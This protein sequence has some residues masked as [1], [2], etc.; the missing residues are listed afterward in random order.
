M[1][2]LPV[3]WY[4]N[5]LMAGM[6]A[7]TNQFGQLTAFL[8]A[9]LVNGFN[10]KTVTSLTQTGGIATAN[11]GASHGFLVD[12][13]ILIT[14]VNETD[15]QGEFR[16][17][18]STTSNITFAVSPS[19]PSTATGTITCKAAPLNW[20]IVFTGT[21]K[22]VYRSL[23]PN[24]PKNM[25]RVDDSQDQTGPYPASYAKKA[26]V[27]MVEANGMGGIDTFTGA[28]APWDPTNPNRNH[29]MSGTAP[30]IYDGW[31]KWYYS[32][33]ESWTAGYFDSNP[34]ENTN[35]KPI[36][37]V[38]DTRG[39]YIYIDSVPG[40]GKSGKCFTD[41]NSY[42]A[43]DKYATLLCAQE[44]WLLANQT[45]STSYNAI[46]VGGYY[47]SNDLFSA[48][49][50]TGNNWGK[51]LLKSHTQL[52]VPVNCTFESFNAVNGTAKSGWSTGVPYLNPTNLSLNLSKIYLKQSN[53][54]SIRGELP[55]IMQVNNN[56]AGNMTDNDIITNVAGYPGKKFLIV[57]FS[58]I[59]SSATISDGMTACYHAF[60]ITGPWW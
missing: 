43:N 2:L 37:V 7:V 48:F 17:L 11:V 47:Y 41:V 18:T 38:G 13:V 58:S 55:G 40:Y 23:D 29:T 49:S 5:L 54:A 50:Y 46:G 56:V 21:N 12:Q 35:T 31:Y 15:Y 36:T 57:R 14:G 24:S 52:G 44:K 27:T 30:A 9:V 51:L 32:L 34:A 8:D 22:R 4:N 59:N 6:P 26:K 28:Q 16:V 45:N 20:E 33:H 19:A 10:S 42:R 39:F 25:L 1:A 53:D 3:K 60:D